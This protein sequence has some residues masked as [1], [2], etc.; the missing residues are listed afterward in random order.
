MA[1]FPQNSKPVNEAF[2]RKLERKYGVRG[3]PTVII[4]LADGTLLGQTGYT[5]AKSD[6]YVQNLA[7]YADFVE[8]KRKLDAAREEQ[9]QALYPRVIPLASKIGKLSMVAAHVRAYD[10]K[11]EKGLLT[12]LIAEEATALHLKQP[13]QALEKLDA[14]AAKHAVASGESAQR[15][16][17][18]RANCLYRLKRKSEMVA[19]LEL[20]VKAAPETPLGLNIKRW[21]NNQQ[22]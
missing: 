9:R 11:N 20:A 12:A 2:N 3:Y 13:K 7:I 21:L 10:P 6:A 16:H 18:A 1:D 4:A 15:F 5:G 17:V 19:A 22:K 8:G 14:F